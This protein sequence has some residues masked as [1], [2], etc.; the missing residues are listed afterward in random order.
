MRKKQGIPAI[1]LRFF[2]FPVIFSCSG[3]KIEKIGS[4][5]SFTKHGHNSFFS[6]GKFVLEAKNGSQG[7]FELICLTEHTQIVRVRAVDRTVEVF[8]FPEQIFA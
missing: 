4:C 1:S 7:T 2:N 6:R 3:V 5:D 8:V